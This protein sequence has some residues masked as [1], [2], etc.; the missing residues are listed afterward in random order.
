[1][2]E[3][4]DCESDEMLIWALDALEDH[5]ELIDNEPDPKMRQ[6]HQDWFVVNKFYV[7]A[8]AEPDL[9]TSL[10]APAPAP[11][12]TGL[13]SPRR[14]RLWKRGKQAR[15][16]HRSRGRKPKRSNVKYARPFDDPLPW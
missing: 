9:F 13:T 8:E 7:I 3:N 12:R 11:E 2:T 1:M 10:V 5:I 6:L 14:E 4:T 15:R 16:D